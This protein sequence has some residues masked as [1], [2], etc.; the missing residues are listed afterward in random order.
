MNN[1]RFPPRGDQFARA[2]RRVAP[3]VSAMPLL[4][5]AGLVQAAPASQCFG[6]VSKGRLEGGVR[7]PLDGLNFSAYSKVAAAAGRTY[8]HSTVERI[9]LAAYASLSEVLPATTYVYG[10]T[11]LAS[12]G[13]FAPHKTHQNGL[14]VDFF[15]PVL[16]REGKS[17]PLPTG[18]MNRFGYDIEF[19]AKA[20]YGE[21]RIDFAALAEHLYQLDVAAR[22]NGARLGLVIIDPR[23]QPALLAT[24]RGRW[25]RRNLPFMKG[26]PWVRHDEHYHVDFA[27]A[28]EPMR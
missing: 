1:N 6:S 4:L 7:L 12:G 11:G 14:S 24:A 27:L 5:G 18:P 22:A 23:F 17:V 21:Y 16:D 9:M 2:L 13:P 3:L 25:L 10:E 15:M 28:C 26:K 19:D 20:R 8:V